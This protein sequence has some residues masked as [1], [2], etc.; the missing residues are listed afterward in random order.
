MSI[1][2]QDVINRLTGS[3]EPHAPTVDRVVAGSEAAVVHGI[4]VT[5]AA[6][7]SVI[8]RTLQAGANLLI[9][10]EGVFYSHHGAE[11]EG[12]T[13]S[14]VYQDKLRLIQSGKLTIYRFHDAPHRYVPDMITQGLVRALGYGDDV[15]KFLPTAAIVTLP[16]AMSVQDIAENV[17]K[18]LGI[19][20][21]RYTGNESSVCSRIGIAVGYRGGGSHAIPL[22]LNEQLDLLITGEG[23]EWET[24]EYIGD[25]A[26]QGRSL[27]LLLLGH[28]ASEEP[29]MECV[30]GLLRDLFPDIPIHFI[31]SE[32]LIQVI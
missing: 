16:E 17:K 5:F 31:P 19:P 11:Y 15:V 27:S 30:A 10:H 14:P 6:S 22:C 29:G 8:Q 13:E 9:T 24:P 2:V 20:Y 1:T 3:T 28:A 7:H 25:A 21:L 23:P 32:P 12:M 26:A 18:K 4:A